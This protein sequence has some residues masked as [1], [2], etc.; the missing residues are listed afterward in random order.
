MALAVVAEDPVEHAPRT[1]FG[2]KGKNV[3]ERAWAEGP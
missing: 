3:E 2:E 1:N